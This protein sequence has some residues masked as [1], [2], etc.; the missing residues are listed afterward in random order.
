MPSVLAKL[1]PSEV[2]RVLSGELGPVTDS[3]PSAAKSRAVQA[4]KV[5]S[6]VFRFLRDILSTSS[7]TICQALGTKAIGVP[8]AGNLASWV[9][10]EAGPR[11][12]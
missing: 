2:G 9:N 5:M 1:A 3:Q 4:S 12:E 7:E 10:V 11:E 6:F 8:W